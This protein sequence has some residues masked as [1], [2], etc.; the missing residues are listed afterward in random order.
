MAKKKKEP[1][2][3]IPEVKKVKT[4]ED[5]YSIGKWKG[6]KQY[7]CKLCAFDTLEENVIKDHIKKEH[8]PKPIKPKVKV[9]LYDR[10]NNK[11]N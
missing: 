4:I 7:K 11:V 3:K 6:F 9:Q 1:E 2:V 8:M 5:Y 10:F